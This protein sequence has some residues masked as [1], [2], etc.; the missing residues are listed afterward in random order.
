MSKSSLD[1]ARSLKVLTAPACSAAFNSGM[2]TEKPNQQPR[3]DKPFVLPP[4]QEKAG[5]SGEGSRSVLPHLKADMRARAVA[6]IAKRVDR[7][8]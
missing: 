5:R 1:Y 6:K 7:D 8:L 2:A 3:Q 4:K